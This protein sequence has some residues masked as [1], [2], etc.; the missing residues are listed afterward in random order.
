[1][2]KQIIYLLLLIGCSI[3]ATAQDPA[4]VKKAEAG[5]PKA[6]LELA[7]YY[8]PNTE[9]VS[10][11]GMKWLTK[12]A[13]N[14]N[15]WAQWKLQCG[16]YYG[17]FGLDKDDEKYVYWL[18]KL[19][20]NS[21]IENYKSEIASA[22]YHL[23]EIYEE[24]GHGLEKNISEYLKWEK[25][26]AF[27]D[28]YPAAQS[29][30]YY[31]EREGD[32]QEAIYWYKKW[33]DM[34][35]AERQEEDEHAFNALRKLGVTYHPAD[36]VGHNHSHS[37][38]DSSTTTSGTSS[39]SQSQGSQV[40]EYIE[41]VPVQ[42]WQACGAC[43]GSGQCQVCYGQGWTYSNLT[44][45]GKKECSACHWSGKCTLCG[46]RGGQNVVRYEQRTVYR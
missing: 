32:K 23:G 2:M 14:G 35:W 39:S 20:D 13:E 28:Y 36:H 18:K 27:N 6:Q 38:A 12:A 7:E 10:A 9:S 19:A 17:W 11:E 5:D 45:N 29:L 3:T 41:T 24:G 37:T 46:G 1:M 16:Y 43:N 31:Y 33:M 34:K 4:L 8:L 22:Q 30:A 21:D 26:A 40:R 15:A 25:K 42:V 44:Y